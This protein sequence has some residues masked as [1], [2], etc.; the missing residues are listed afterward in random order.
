MSHNPD[1]TTGDIKDLLNEL[2]TEAPRVLAATKA[3]E[4]QIFNGIQ[5][6]KLV[7]GS[8]IKSSALD[9]LETNERNRVLSSIVGRYFE[10]LK[11]ETQYKVVKDGA[12]IA[13]LQEEMAVPHI[14]VPPPK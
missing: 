7:N 2:S 13:L 5:Q 9:K 1:N 3:L 8:H 4:H 14:C 6:D 12:R 11:S 10:H